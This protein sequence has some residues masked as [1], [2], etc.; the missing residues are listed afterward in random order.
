MSTT[1]SQDL[2]PALNEELERVQGGDPEGLEVGSTED[3]T[4]LTVFDTQEQRRI[5]VD[6]AIN[7]HER[8]KKLKN[9]AGF[10]AAWRALI[11]LPGWEL[12]DQ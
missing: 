3:F 6:T 10:E 12:P 7:W 2:I 1:T 4:V 9:N 8:L 11:A 5:S